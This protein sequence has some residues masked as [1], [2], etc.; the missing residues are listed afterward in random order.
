[1][2]AKANSATLLGV[3]A[4][5]V[6]V[7]VDVAPGLPAFTVVGLP[8]TAVQ[9]S[10]E[11]VRAAIKNSGYQFPASRITVNLA[12]ADVR[13]EGSAFDLPMALCL[14]SAMGL[15]ITEKLGDIL[16]AGELALD[17]SLRPIQGAI[18]IAL[19]ALEHGF[20]TVMLP[21]ANSQEA[22]VIEGIE[23]ISPNNLVE[24]VNH[25][26]GSAKLQA[27]LP[28]VATQTEEDVLCFSDIKGQTQSKRAL[29][30]AVCGGHNVLLVG[31]PGSGKT[32][33]ARRAATLRPSLSDR[34]ALEVTRIHSA[35]GKMP[36]G[37]IREAQFIHVHHGASEAGII[38]GGS[39]PRP[40]A[41]SLAHNGILFLDELPE[42][43]RE[44][45]EGLRQP[46]EDRVVTIARAR[47]SL[48]FPASFQLIAAMNPSPSGDWVEPSNPNQ[49]R[50]LAKIS[51]P[52]LDRMDLVVSVPKLGIEDLTK[53]P[54]GETSA[55]IRARVSAARTRMLAR[56][57]T[58][59]AELAG[60]ALRQHASLETSPENFIR[61][62]AKQ[63]N[64]SGRGYD[65]ILRVARTIAD[66]AN[67][68]KILEPHL[69]EAISYRQ[70]LW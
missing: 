34:E 32:M 36:R 7:E 66:L 19:A 28:E 47:A 42:F 68:E 6:A 30:I 41:V 29:E 44:A 48:T 64:L 18:N 53:A 57:N 63:L 10:R 58:S 43:T 65:R 49:R 37:L 12:P 8:D 13:K 3:E 60:R 45:L 1:M 69:A 38:G 55:N 51:G 59:N 67:S 20:K 15:V 24:A 26:N 17:G 9:E 11:R 54:T 2:L 14:C 46:M 27:V 52:L 40:G 50:Y 25:L 21:P 56:Q 33:L 4:V 62:A 16:I 22:A 35:A 61:A 5:P 31:P 39:V 70:K 23:V